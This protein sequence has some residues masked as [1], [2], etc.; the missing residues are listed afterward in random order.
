CDDPMSPE[1]RKVFVRG[2]CV[3]FSPTVINQFLERSVEAVA[4]MEVT[5]NVICKTITGNQVKQWP[6]KDKLS[7]IKLTVKYAILNKIAAVN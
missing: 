6:R 7:S 3:E 5:D 4:E 2:N 1:Y